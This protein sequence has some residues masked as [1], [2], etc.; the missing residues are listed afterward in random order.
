[1]PADDVRVSLFDFFL[2][3]LAL[4]LAGLALIAWIM[5]DWSNGGFESYDGM[6]TSAIVGIVIGVAALLAGLV[7][8]TVAAAGHGTRLALA[9]RDAERAPSGG[10]TPA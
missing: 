2:R 3:G 10:T 8:L 6:P 4:A 1:M 9:E 7:C 5:G